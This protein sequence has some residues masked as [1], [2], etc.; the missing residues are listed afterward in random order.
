LPVL[1]RYDLA[2][3]ENWL[4]GFERQMYD[5]PRQIR[6]TPAPTARIVRPVMTPRVDAARSKIGWV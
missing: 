6:N 5:S 1:D 2:A 4:F 3:F